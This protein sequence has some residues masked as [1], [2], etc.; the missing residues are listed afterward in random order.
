[1]RVYTVDAVVINGFEC[2][3]SSVRHVN[4][5]LLRHAA[6]DSVIDFQCYC[7]VLFVLTFSL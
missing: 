1:M 3:R 6:A 5:C 4:D 2:G 7:I